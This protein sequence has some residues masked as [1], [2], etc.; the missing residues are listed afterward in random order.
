MTPN[1]HISPPLG[2]FSRLG[3]DLFVSEILTKL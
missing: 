1:A 2:N 3:N